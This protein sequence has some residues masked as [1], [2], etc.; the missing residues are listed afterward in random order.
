MI[1]S[2]MMSTRESYNWNVLQI[3]FNYPEEYLVRVEGSTRDLNY[4]V[5]GQVVTSLTFTTNQKTYGP[6]GDVNPETAF[7]SA[8]GIV[9]GFFGRCGHLIDSIGV[10][11]SLGKE[12]A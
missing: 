8:Y 9:V 1:G 7:R 10:Y 5:T 2:C 4:G 12:H 3:K 6:Y 11:V